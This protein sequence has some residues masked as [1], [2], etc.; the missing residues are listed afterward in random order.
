MRLQPAENST[1]TEEK[2]GVRKGVL[3]YTIVMKKE[4]AFLPRNL[5]GFSVVYTN[6]PGG[7]KLN[8]FSI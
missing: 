8:R 1:T 7:E 2:G 6:K 5:G 3:N 4:S